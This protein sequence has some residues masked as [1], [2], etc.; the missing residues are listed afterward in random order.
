M[1]SYLVKKR[2]ITIL[3]FIMAFVI[4]A[5][6]FFQL[7]NQESPDVTIRQAMVTT[8]YPGASPE[9]VE[10]SVTKELEQK[11]KEV[12][13]V[14]E[15]TSTSGNG[16]STI[17]VEAED[18]ADPKVVWDEMRKKVEDA[19]SE[20]PDGAEIPVINDELLSSFIGSYAIIADSR[21][22][23]YE[24]NST[25]TTWE[26]QLG[27]LD[28]ISDVTITGLPE[29]E[30]RISIDTQKLEQYQLSWGRVVQAMQGRTDLMPT[31]DVEF[32]DRTYQLIVKEIENVEELNRLIIT[33]TQ[34]G[35]PV[36]LSDIG[37][38]RL[39]HENAAYYAYVSDKPAI[40]ISLGAET[41]TDVPS[42]NERVNEK[43]AELEKGLPENVQLV[44]LY[45][46]QDKVSEILGDLSHEMLMAIAAVL[47]ICT[48]GLNLLTSS[49]VALAIPVS[50]AIAMIF[51]SP[52]GVTLNQ[53]SVVGLI[54]VLGILVDDAVVVNDNIERRLTDFGESPAEAALKGTKEVS[55]SILTATLATIFAFVPL[56]FLAGDA[57]SFIKPIPIIIALTML[58]SMLMSLS[59]VP[60]FREWYETRRLQK[61]KNNNRRMKPAGLLGRQIQSLTHVYSDKLM[62]KIVKKPLLTALTGLLFATAAY[63]LVLFTPIS[64]FPDAEDPNMTLNIE[65][66]VG[67]SFTETNRVVNDVAAWINQ[68]PET[69]KITYAIGGGAPQLFSDM[70]SSAEEGDVYGQI[71]IIGKEGIFDLKQ[72]P[73][74]WNQ[75]FI[76]NYPGVKITESF[77]TIGFPVGKPV[78][79]RVTGPDTEQLQRLTQQVRESITKIDGTKSIT[80]NMGIERYALE[81]KVNQQA[82]DKYLVSYADLTKAL[83]L[84]NEG[85][86]VS[87][88][89]TGSNLI[90]INVYIDEEGTDPNLLLQ[91]LNVTNAAGTQIPLSQLVEANPTFS[92][93]QINHY[94]LERSVTIESELEGRT[95][96]EVSG[97]LR[98]QLAQI[99]FPEGYKWETSGETSDQNEIFAELGK[100]YVVVIFLII[101]LVT[102]QFYSISISAI[103]MTTVYLAAAGGVIGIFVSGL[104]LGFMSIMGIISLA[105]IVVRNGIVMIEFIEDAR[106]EGA[107]L[108]ESVIAA[109]RARFRP[110]LLTSLTAIVGM[111]PIAVTGSLLFK[112]LAYA[113]IFG[114]LFSTLLTLFVVPSLYMLLAKYKLRRKLKKELPSA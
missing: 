37:T 106:R 100:L 109:T 4:G 96:T 13:G 89:D 67:T 46:Q 22:T 95:A 80:D 50:I 42:M 76:D 33:R 11:I 26:D 93:Q 86:T 107:G 5:F 29:Q 63:G 113:I 83:L 105:G 8:I 40:R 62:P 2:K 24:L 31:G 102:I 38:A 68:Q 65:L 51:L 28:G 87:D 18:D 36:Y 70:N 91:R 85:V 6:C 77:P 92:I 19:Q 7:P 74:Q 111:I 56:L 79:V 110:I 90:D 64:L 9:K 41:G 1:I 21:D 61:H 82:M 15:I 84:L 81:L 60:I 30:V 44:T 32:N 53:I 75:Y 10:Q 104:P 99:S 71:S 101:I 48:L 55:V 66:P 54:I 88:F 97:E 20:L 34:S 27:A 112:P 59:I 49:F 72:T 35:S 25:M 52:F 94:N 114:L 14:S 12:E 23:L 47:L 108:E 16:I 17:M 69:E 98:G 58:A 43:L 78:S 57:G 45:A 39:T 103:V 3:F 73:E